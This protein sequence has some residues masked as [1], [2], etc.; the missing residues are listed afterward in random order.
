[1]DVSNESLEDEPSL[2]Y[3]TFYDE[4]LQKEVKVPKLNGI[5]NLKKILISNVDLTMFRSKQREV[6]K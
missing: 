6:L 5:G 2:N 3:F 4:S 1:M